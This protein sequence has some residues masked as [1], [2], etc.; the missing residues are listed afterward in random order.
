MPD[1]QYGKIYKISSDST[2]KIYIGSTS[3]QYLS[4]RLNDHKQS[5]KGFLN[6]KIKY[7]SAFDVLIFPDCKIILIESFPC[8]SK[9][10]LFAREDFHIKDLKEKG[11]NVVNKKL[12]NIKTK[13]EQKEWF[14]QHYQNNKQQI[15]AR[16]KSKRDNAIIIKCE[17]GSEIKSY[18]LN[19]HKK[20]IKHKSFA[21]NCI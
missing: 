11:V 21:I 7:Y 16:D 18:K 14:K 9:D 13:E 1:Y 15:N 17:C 5:Y 4:S 8:K 2:D 3:K 10:E 6:G 12:N 20:T 19:D